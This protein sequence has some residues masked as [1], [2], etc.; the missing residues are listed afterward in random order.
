MEKRDYWANK[1][2]AWYLSGQRLKPFCEQHGINKNDIRKWLYKLNLPR[3]VRLQ[4]ET[5]GISNIQELKFIP[6]KLSDIELLTK[7]SDAIDILLS[8]NYRIRIRR[9]FDGDTLTRLLMV[10]G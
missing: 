4:E 9:G 7:E 6:V 8:N 10:M 5:E 2:T 1:V 3:P